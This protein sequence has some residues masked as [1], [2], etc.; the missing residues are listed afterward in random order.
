M[1]TDAATKLEGRVV[2]AAETAL[3]RRKF[4]A[5]IDVLAGLGWLPPTRIHEWRC[6]QCGGTGDFLMM[7]AGEPRCLNCAGLGSLVFLL[8]GDATLTRRA[9]KASAM[10][11]VVVRF[12]RTR[13][14]YER[15]GLLVEEA[16]LEQAG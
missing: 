3:A 2:Q 5:P 1:T 13:K 4:V 15:Q 6:S 10:T 16:A 7:E 11:A 8:S 9:H 12:S 14:R